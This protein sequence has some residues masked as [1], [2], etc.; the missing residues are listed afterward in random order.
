MGR[1]R[2]TKTLR[3]VLA[4]IKEL[5]I[6]AAR[7]GSS[8]KPSGLVDQDQTMVGFDWFNTV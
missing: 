1:R 7:N 6:A 2:P 3:L 5:Q 4:E 8:L